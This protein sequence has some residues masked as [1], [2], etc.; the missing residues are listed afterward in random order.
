MGFKAYAL[1]TL[2][3][4]AISRQ[5]LGDSAAMSTDPAVDLTKMSTAEIYMND[6]HA[7]DGRPRYLAAHVQ[8][9]LCQS[10]EAFCQIVHE[11]SMGDKVTLLCP[12]SCKC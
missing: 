3:H 6:N 9:D 10:R 11:P 1:T 12:S 8:K 4:Q 2:S 5:D 7:L